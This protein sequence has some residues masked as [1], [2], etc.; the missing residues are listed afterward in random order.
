M[1]PKSTIDCV[2]CSFLHSRKPTSIYASGSRP[3]RL[4]FYPKTPL[5]YIVASLNNSVLQKAFFQSRVG[6][7]FFFLCT[8]E[9]TKFRGERP[10]RTSETSAAR[11]GCTCNCKLVLMVDAIGLF[12]QL[13]CCN[14]ATGSYKDIDS[15]NVR[16]I[17]FH[18]RCRVQG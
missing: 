8:E 12:L 15:H 13:K 1:T 11:G 3:L 18:R 10:S 6:T 7:T 5:I 2:V 9:K 17:V 16:T 14:I 4:L